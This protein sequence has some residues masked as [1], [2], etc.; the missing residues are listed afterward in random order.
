VAA[1]S[2]GVME[3]LDTFGL[4]AELP[5]S[6]DGTLTYHGHCQQTAVKKDQHAV[7]V[8]RRAGY[9]VDDLDSTCCGMAGSFGYEAEH[10]SMSTAIADLLFDQV[11]K[12]PGETVVAP[13][14]SCR[15]QLLEHEGTA[16]KPPH[17]VELLADKL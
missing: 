11:E 9:E 1:N 7:A 5:V 16:G 4:D 3:Y 6:A 14:T 8:L 13:G 2:Y 12:S 17:P 10:Y 15:S